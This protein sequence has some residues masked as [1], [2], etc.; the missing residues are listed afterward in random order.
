MREQSAFQTHLTL[1]VSTGWSELAVAGVKALLR[2][3]FHSAPGGPGTYLY[4]SGKSVNQQ[5]NPRRRAIASL[6]SRS[7]ALGAPR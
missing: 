7:L 2:F 5:L 4:E 3:P 6:Q 1:G